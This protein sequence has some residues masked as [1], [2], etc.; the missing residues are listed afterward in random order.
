MK[1]IICIWQK[2]RPNDAISVDN[3]SAVCEPH[4]DAAYAQDANRS[5]R[6]LVEFVMHA[7]GQRSVPFGDLTGETK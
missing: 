7:Q 2:G 3:G 5:T 1:C 6:D 4:L